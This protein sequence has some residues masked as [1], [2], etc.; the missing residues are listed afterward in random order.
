MDLLEQLFER[1]Q[2]SVVVR[3]HITKENS[4]YSVHIIIFTGERDYF[5][6]CSAKYQMEGRRWLS[7]TSELQRFSIGS[8][9]GCAE[10]QK[11]RDFL[12]KLFATHL[13]SLRENVQFIATHEDSGADAA[14]SPQILICL[15]H[16]VA[17]LQGQVG[18]KKYESLDGHSIYY[19]E[20]M[21][22]DRLMGFIGEQME[23]QRQ[24]GLAFLRDH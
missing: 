4:G 7:K 8:Y 14:T 19:W 13:C 6:A 16:L 20:S 2:T 3:M 5:I 10:S 22:C 17:Y 21:L 9:P 1:A 18:I 24:S 15:T 23:R 11:S 12:S